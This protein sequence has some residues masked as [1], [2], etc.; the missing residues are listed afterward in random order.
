MP[1]L[2]DDVSIANK[3]LIKI[4]EAPVSSLDDAQSKSSRIMKAL[5]PQ[6]KQFVFRLPMELPT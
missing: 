2:I 4:A 1:D 5:L 6:A 3:A